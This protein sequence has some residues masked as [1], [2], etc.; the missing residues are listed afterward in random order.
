M[1]FAN[2]IDKFLFVYQDDL[3]S[4]SKGENDHCMHLEKEFIKALKYGNSLNPRK[5]NFGVT[6]G[7]LLGHLVGNHGVRIELERV[8][9]PRR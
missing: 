2:I 6:E 8:E 5:C 7:K 9:A 1:A 3:T 4:Y